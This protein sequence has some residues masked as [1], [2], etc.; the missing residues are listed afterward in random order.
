M[1][2]KYF[3]HVDKILEHLQDRSGRTSYVEV[4]PVNQRV[5]QVN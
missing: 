1:K 5:A 3:S 2:L 4:E